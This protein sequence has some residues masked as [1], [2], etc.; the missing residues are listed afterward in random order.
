MIDWNSEIIIY[1]VDPVLF[2]QCFDDYDKFHN[3]LRKL[4][5]PDVFSG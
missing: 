2:S 3:I 1:V 4:N 5:A